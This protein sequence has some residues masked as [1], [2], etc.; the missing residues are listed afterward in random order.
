MVW[1]CAYN[2]L[3]VNDS[4]VENDTLHALLVTTVSHGLLDLLS[5]DGQL[6]VAEAAQAL[7]VS[8]ATIRRIQKTKQWGYFRRHRQRYESRLLLLRSNRALQRRH[9]LRHQPYRTSSS[10]ALLFTVGKSNYCIFSIRGRL[11][12]CCSPECGCSRWCIELWRGIFW[13]R[14]THGSCSHICGSVE[15]C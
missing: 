14:S 3:L 13:G 5:G 2:G 10:P 6:T 12:E 9:G 4:D 11:S 1:I 15:P 8:Q 7:G